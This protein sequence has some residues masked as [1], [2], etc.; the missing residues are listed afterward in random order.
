MKSVNNLSLGVVILA[1]GLAASATI[2]GPGG[3]RSKSQTLIRRQAAQI[4]PLA[5]TARKHG[6]TPISLKFD[7]RT[8]KAFQLNGGG[9][10]KS[11]GLSAFAPQAGGPYLTGLSVS[12]HTNNDDKDWDSN[13]EVAVDN[14]R[15]LVGRGYVGYGTHFG[16]GSDHGPFV[17]PIS[18]YYTPADLRSGRLFVIIHPN[19]NDTWKFRTA[20]LLF[21]FSDGSW[22]SWGW[23]DTWV[24][25]SARQSLHVWP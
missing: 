12:F 7:A 1:L 10:G 17:I 2:A 20:R 5:P 21:Q 18:G 16:D 8:A 22:Q 25:E 19:G 3:Q 23:G 14:H 13:I 15:W 4:R 11:T 6:S 9:T 24:S